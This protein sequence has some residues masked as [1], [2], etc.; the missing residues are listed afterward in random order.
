M[1]PPTMLAG[2]TPAPAAPPP[3]AARAAPEPRGRN[4]NPPPRVDLALALWLTARA[5]LEREVSTL[6]AAARKAGKPAPRAAHIDKLAHADEVQRTRDLLLDAGGESRLTDDDR[7]LAARLVKA[8]LKQ[9]KDAGRCQC[10][11]C[12]GDRISLPPPW[13]P[14]DMNTATSNHFAKHFYASLL[15]LVSTL[16]ASHHAHNKIAFD[17][18][19]H[20]GRLSGH[21]W[22][23]DAQDGEESECRARHAIGALSRDLTVVPHL[24]HGLHK[25]VQEYLRESLWLV[26]L[27]GTK[28]VP[29]ATLKAFQS[30]R[31]AHQA[32]LDQ[33]LKH[34]DTWLRLYVGRSKSSE[35]G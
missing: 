31:D 5:R 16:Q 32:G 28:P 22:S 14:P 9:D 29:D 10:W 6:K 20:L 13:S 17:L 18:N 2:W 27:Q 19:E 3:P 1:L 23:Y 35:Q 24:L 12:A 34:Y 4:G 26:T 8:A 21:D 15:T 25:A 7:A 33:V 11:R 30:L